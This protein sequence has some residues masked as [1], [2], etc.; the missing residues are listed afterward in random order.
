VTKDCDQ[1]LKTKILAERE[2]VAMV[3]DKLLNHTL[4]LPSSFPPEY[5]IDRIF[6]LARFV[7]NGRCFTI[8]ALF[9]IQYYIYIQY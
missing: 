7:C 8:L 2:V 3:W 4:Y 9:Y 6:N 5:L 1:L